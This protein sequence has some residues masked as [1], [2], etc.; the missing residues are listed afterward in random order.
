MARCARNYSKIRGASGRVHTKVFLIVEGFVQGLASTSA[1][2]DDE[3]GLDHDNVKNK[4]TL[5]GGAQEA[6]IL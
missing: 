3:E 1:T 6:M 5:E 2:G 4:F